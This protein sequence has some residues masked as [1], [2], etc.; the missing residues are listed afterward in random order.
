M[1]QKR[2]F[3]LIC[4]FPRQ[5]IDKLMLKAILGRHYSL[6]DWTQNVSRRLWYCTHSHIQ[7]DAPIG[8]CDIPENEENEALI[9]IGSS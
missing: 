7:S 6:S 5:V 4:C 8:L 3:S 1:A 2:E 9:K